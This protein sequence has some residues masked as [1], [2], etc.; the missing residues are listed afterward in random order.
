MQDIPT[1]G[2]I[3]KVPD[4]K[5]AKTERI[6]HST[7]LLQKKAKQFSPRELAKNLTKLQMQILNAITHHSRSADFLS[8]R[9]LEKMLPNRRY[10]I[11]HSLSHL[12]HLGLAKGIKAKRTIHYCPATKVKSLEKQ[13]SRIAF[14]DK[15]EDETIQTVRE[16]L[17]RLYPAAISSSS[18]KFIASNKNTYFDIVFKFKSCVAG[19]KFLA[20]D[21]FAKMPVTK[22]IVQSFRKKLGWAFNDSRS[23]VVADT[24]ACYKPTQETLGVI[25]C[26]KASR[27]AMDLAESCDISLLNFREAQLCR[28]QLRK[29]N[30]SLQ[31]ITN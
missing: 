17:K 24:D 16:S 12:L 5:Q 31:I 19:K 3:P 10:E 22:Q 20:A 18:D 13:A 23:T 11:T 14:C 2:H 7:L 6:A 28:S 15:I 27:K 21:V 26:N 4:K 1:G 25:I 29:P 9:D 8:L 30:N